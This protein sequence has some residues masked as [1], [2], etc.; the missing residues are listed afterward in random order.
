MRIRTLDAVVLAVGALLVGCAPEGDD[1]EIGAAAAADITELARVAEVAASSPSVSGEVPGVGDCVW[2]WTLG[3][4]TFEAGLRAAP[5]GGEVAGERVQIQYEVT[6]GHLSGP[7]T[8]SAGA[9]S[10]A[11]SGE[12]EATTTT[13]TARRGE[14]SHDGTLIVDSLEGVAADD[15]LIGPFDLEARYTGWL[16]GSWSLS[17][18]VSEAG[19]LE[20]LLVGPRGGSCTIG[21]TAEAPEIACE[22]VAEERERPR[23]LGR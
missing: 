19:E 1:S 23:R 16:D 18:S 8:L 13:Y 9:V 3:G 21:G 2:D 6:A 15:G 7:A 22:G 17:A 11:L 5:C 12:R 10:Y 4:G 14:R 20:G